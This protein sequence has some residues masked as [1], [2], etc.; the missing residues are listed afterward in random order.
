V[1]SVPTNPALDQTS[2]EL[3]RLTLTPGLGPTLTRRAIETL[4]SAHA[5]LRA[6]AQ[7]LA[8]VPRIGLP[9]ARSIWTAIRETDESLERELEAAAAQNVSFVNLFDERYPE[10]LKTIPDPPIMLRVRGSLDP[11]LDRYALA[12]VGSRSCSIAAQE[13]TTRFASFLASSGLTIVSGGARGIDTAA[14]K[15]ALQAGGR[16]IVVLGNGLSHTY[17]P[18]NHDLFENIVESGGCLV[19]ELP[20]HAQP[21]RENFPARNRIISGLSLGV[22]V[23]EAGARSGALITARQA[24]EEQG[25]EVMAMPGA[26]SDA[27]CAGS[28]AL[29]RDGGASMVLEPADILHLLES[30]ARH[31]HLGTHTSRFAPPAASATSQSEAHPQIYV[32][33]SLAHTDLSESQCKLLDALDQPRDFDELTRIT[34]LASHTLRADATMLELKKLIARRGGLLARL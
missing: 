30:P 4:G 2:F 19:S 12:I 3:L 28:N 11:S 16:T 1:T 6:S 21:A 8:T 25:R 23:T 22:L 29:L 13:Q 27:R 32:K 26:I 10:L 15:A 18:E 9:S 34:S 33:T 5:V 20:M 17:P 24:V 7:Q 31:A 14:H